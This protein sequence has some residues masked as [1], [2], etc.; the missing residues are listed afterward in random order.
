LARTGVIRVEFGPGPTVLDRG[1]AD[2]R[3]NLNFTSVRRPAFERTSQRGM[4]YL[5]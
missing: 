1:A 4:S 5:R 3:A 2:F